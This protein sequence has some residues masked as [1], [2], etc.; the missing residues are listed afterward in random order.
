MS[1]RPE[2]DVDAALVQKMQGTHDV[3]GGLDLVIDVLNASPIGREQRNRMMHLVDPQECRVTD[4]VADPSIADLCPERFV[5][6]W[7]GRAQ[8]DVTET[9]NTGV[10]GTMVAG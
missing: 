6:H 8:A 5:T 2:C 1:S 7:V 3:V 10:A 9:S 4:P